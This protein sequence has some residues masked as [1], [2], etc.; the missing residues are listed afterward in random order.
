MGRFNGQ[1]AT[2]EN[3]IQRKMEKF[4]WILRRVIED[5]GHTISL[6]EAALIA[7]AMEE[8]YDYETYIK[9]T[10]DNLLA[11]IQVS[12]RYDKDGRKYGPNNDLK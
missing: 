10:Q 11:D 3:C 2:K 6:L 7:T 12:L 9:L 4:D 5:H 8:R 1:R